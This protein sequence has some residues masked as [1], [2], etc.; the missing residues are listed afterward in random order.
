MSCF[1][2]LSV[3]EIGALPLDMCTYPPPQGQPGVTA[4]LTLLSGERL[5]LHSPIRIISIRYSL[6]PVSP[7]NCFIYRLV[8][9]VLS[10]LPVQCREAEF[11]LGD[12]N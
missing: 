6:D 5:Y 8:I 1:C 10:F 4:V 3:H 11:R 2:L 12:D 7:P 9:L